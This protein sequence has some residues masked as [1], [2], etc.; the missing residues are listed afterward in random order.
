MLFTITPFI[1]LAALV[2]IPGAFAAA[3]K[4]PSFN[5]VAFGDSLS[6][7][8]NSF[9]LITNKTMPPSPYYTNGRWSNGPVWAEY[10]AQTA[11]ANLVDLAFGI[12]TSNTDVN[13]AIEHGTRYPTMPGFVQQV[14]QFLSRR[15]KDAKPNKTVATVWTGGNDYIHAPELGKTVNAA[16]VVAFTMQGINKLIDAGYDDL[17]VFNL[18]P[19]SYVPFA[20]HNLR[21][22]AAL[23]T[24]KLTKP[25]ANVVAIDMV[26]TF[27]AIAGQL[28]VKNP[29]TDL[30]GGCLD[31]TT[32]TICPNVQDF[33]LWDG[34]HPTTA[35]HALIAA[36]V[37]AVAKVA[38]PKY[39]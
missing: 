7:N 25:K 21:L 33:A 19:S 30:Q 3:I 36:D 12:S 11:N 5:I 10:L 28:L 24:L 39:F 4:K 1:A 16:D 29:K 37:G 38:F 22:G 17:I 32:M 13:P 34:L 2:S 26:A 31:L 6:D 9:N 18:P 14:D 27:A 20:E 15:S 23:A 35:T 8:G